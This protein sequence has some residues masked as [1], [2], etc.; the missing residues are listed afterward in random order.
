MVN[1]PRE[2]C[3]YEL[4][5]H[6][7][8]RRH[9]RRHAVHDAAE[10]EAMIEDVVGE[11]SG[12]GFGRKETF[13]VR[14]ALEEAVVNAIKHGHHNDPSRTVRVRYHVTPTCVLA[15][16]EDEGPGFR[17]EDVPDPRRPENLERDSGRG[18]LLMRSYMTWVRYNETG[19]RVTLCKRHTAS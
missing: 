1:N 4:Q 8:G 19:N 16:V 17:P 9:W 5:D 13:A 7:G 3:P 11:L 15:E 6:G 14:L 2:A 18:L 12:A 10:M